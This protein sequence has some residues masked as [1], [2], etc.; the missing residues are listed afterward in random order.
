MGERVER[1]GEEGQAKGRIRGSKGGMERK[2]HDVIGMK[3]E[4][5]GGKYEEGRTEQEMERKITKGK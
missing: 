4:G 1:G 3:E 5:E 2:M